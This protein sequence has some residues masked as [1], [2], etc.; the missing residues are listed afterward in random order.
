M[1][2]APDPLACDGPMIRDHAWVGVLRM[3]PA[4]QPRVRAADRRPH[5]D[6]RC[7]GFGDKQAYERFES[8]WSQLRNAN[9]Q[10]T[11]IV[12]YGCWFYTA[13]N[14]SGWSAAYVNV[15]HS[16][17]LRVRCDANEMLYGSR[18][19]ANALCSHSPGDKYWCELARMR[20]YDSI[21]IQRGTATT[22]T[23]RR[24]PWSEL[25]LCTDECARETF[26]ESACVP[27]ARAMSTTGALLPCNCPSGAQTLSCDGV[28]RNRH[29]QS[30]TPPT[31]VSVLNAL[32]L[33]IS[34]ERMPPQNAQRCTAAPS[35]VRPRKSKAASLPPP[36]SVA[37]TGRSAVQR[38]GSAVHAHG[39]TRQ[40]LERLTDGRYKGPPR[41]Q[42][43]VTRR[44]AAPSVTQWPLS[45]PLRR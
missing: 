37:A 5:C 16:L 19:S 15:G 36:P 12:N 34:G 13:P 24:K 4:L 22:P 11:D 29:L 45:W 8:I 1:A 2:S 33:S 39:F 9:V 43:Q 38:N 44:R 25:I 23:G 40:Q 18:A 41:A 26:S 28:D 17:R 20:G 42:S 30:S 7:R 6:G 10:N 35:W 27:M 3:A 31:P 32:P 21:Q 14:A